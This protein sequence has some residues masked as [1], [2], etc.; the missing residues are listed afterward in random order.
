M[1]ANRPVSVTPPRWRRLLPG[2]LPPPW[3]PPPPRWSYPP[4]RAPPP[5]LDAGATPPPR[6]RGCYGPIPWGAARRGAS[7]ARKRRTTVRLL[8]GSG[9]GAAI[10]RTADSGVLPFLTLERIHADQGL[11][12]HRSWWGVERPWSHRSATAPRP[13]L[14]FQSSWALDAEM[15]LTDRL[16]FSQTPYGMPSL[17]SRTRHRRNNRGS[18]CRF[19]SLTSS[20]AIFHWI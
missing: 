5:P 3:A 9:P 17:S 12:V 2:E 14:S 15:N 10:L 16:G 6:W 7:C 8:V 19:P 20:P 18:P 11:S 4:P 13:V 1:L